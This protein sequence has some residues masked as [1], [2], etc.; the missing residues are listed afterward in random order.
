M[1]ANPDISWEAPPEPAGGAKA[2]VWSPIAAAV[3]KR[4]GQWAKV[5]TY[6][7][8]ASARNIASHINKGRIA[9]FDGGGYEATSRTNHDGTYSIYLRYVGGE[10]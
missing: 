2:G 5:R 1:T 3:K 9:A 7:G 6:S 10:A 8:S 4:P